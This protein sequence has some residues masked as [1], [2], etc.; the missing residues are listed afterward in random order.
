[1][2][3]E[4]IC[5][6]CASKLRVDEELAGKRARC[7]QCGSVYTV[8]PAVA[9]RADALAETVYQ[10]KG[11]APPWRLRTPDGTLYG[12]VSRNELDQ[13]VAEG[14]VPPGSTIQQGADG[15]WQPASDV[16]PQVYGARPVLTAAANP[17]ADRPA[18][19]EIPYAIPLPYGQRRPH[20][21]P[22][23]AVL[24]VL[25]LFVCPP[26]GLLAWLLGRAD[27]GDMRMGTM[28]PGGLALTQVGTILGIVAMVLGI[29]SLAVGLMGFLS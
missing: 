10:P 25:A 27:I 18:D 20:R 4:T 13:W 11:G 24:G 29:L 19:T 17:F 8:P 9:T 22:L 1:M 26:L 23:I 2:P 12:P 5:Q 14:R 21:G 16:F 15:P 7:P 3:I 28:D 6:K